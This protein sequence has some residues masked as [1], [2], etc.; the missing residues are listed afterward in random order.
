MKY[1]IGDWIQSAPNSCDI[2]LMKRIWSAQ[3]WKIKP[4]KDAPDG[5]CYVTVGWWNGENLK[6][7]PTLRQ[8]WSDSIV[9]KTE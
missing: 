3:I 6:K 2:R 8:L 1:K 7:R 9:S 4:C 5:N